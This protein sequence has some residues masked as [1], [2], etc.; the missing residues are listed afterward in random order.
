MSKISFLPYH[1][2]ELSK[3]LRTIS[4]LYLG[5]LLGHKK[6]KGAVDSIYRKLCVLIYVA[7]YRMH[8]PQALKMFLNLPP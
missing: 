3:V 4:V 6:L 8:R 1:F 7:V 2:H 5:H